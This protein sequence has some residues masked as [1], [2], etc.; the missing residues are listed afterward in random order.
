MRRGNKPGGH[1]PDPQRGIA[2]PAVLGVILILFLIVTSVLN[3]TLNQKKQ[4]SAKFQQTSMTLVADAAIASEIKNLLD[5]KIKSSA[6]GRVEQ[7]SIGEFRV[8][9]SVTSEE[10]RINLNKAKYALIFAYF[11]EIGLSSGGARGLANALTKQREAAEGFKTLGEV[12][13]V[14]GMS[15]ALL[16]D[17]KPDVTLYSDGAGVK[18]EFASS[19]VQQTLVSMG[20]GDFS[21]KK[22]VLKPEE[23]STGTV[24]RITATVEGQDGHLFTLKQ[25]IRLTGV[26]ENP[27]L[28]HSRENI[29]F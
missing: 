21:G 17:M 13:L 4:V 2:L 20:K 23:F 7:M 10:G 18:G 6:H 27:Y 5:L 25:I 28:I 15:G 22:S 14:P 12:L 16:Q 29:Y 8:L 3:L 24:W 19:R 11:K 1:F 26:S 9:V